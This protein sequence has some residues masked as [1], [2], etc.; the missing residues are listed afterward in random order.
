MSRVS[1]EMVSKEINWVESSQV[2]TKERKEGKREMCLLQ[3][4]SHRP[5]EVNAKVEG[6]KGNK[7]IFAGLLAS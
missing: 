5:K 6:T 3:V 1:L 7:E 4:P 2:N